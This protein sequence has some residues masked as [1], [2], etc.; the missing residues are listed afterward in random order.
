V[1]VAAGVARATVY[2]YFPNRARLL[3]ELTRVAAEDANERLAAARIEDVAVEEGLSRAARAFVDLGDAFVVLADERRSP[4]TEDFDRL[5]AAPIRR[6]LEAGRSAGAI[7]ADV[8]IALLAESLIGLVA[9]VQRHGSLGRDDT[10]AAAV[11]L[12]MHGAASADQP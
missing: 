1:A 12:F 2:R 3:D 11:G 5:V 4:G 8:P 10:V 7:R 9:S 6:L